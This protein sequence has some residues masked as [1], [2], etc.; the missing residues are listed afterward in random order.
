M[1]AR[2]PE[3]RV[4]RAAPDVHEQDAP[5][6]RSTGSSGSVRR[7]HAG[8]YPRPEPLAPPAAV[9]FDALF[10]RYAKY[11][12]A[13]AFRLLGRDDDEV[14]DVVQDVFWIASRKLARIY[15]LDAAR[16]WLVT[17]AV[18]VVRRKLR[19]RR[20]RWALLGE[21]VL[22]N[23]PAPG[24]TADQRALLARIY[25]VLETVASNDRIAWLL[26]HVEGERL[27]DVALAC[28]CSLA[29]AKR[30]IASAQHVLD[31]VLRDG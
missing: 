29:T 28:Q 19:R 11:V 24:V 6:L 3:L 13:V 4:V 1:S 20:W 15:D 7:A 12:A 21:A 18:R 8:P 16:P 14:D 26:R 27:E 5:N 10:A 31:E 30:R 22:S 9:A 23:V 2:R 17:V 25:R